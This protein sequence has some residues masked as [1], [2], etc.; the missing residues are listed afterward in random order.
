MAP[1]TTKRVTKVT[2]PARSKAASMSPT[3]HTAPR[4]KRQLKSALSTL[5]SSPAQNQLDA[6][7]HYDLLSTEPES[8]S[9]HRTKGPSK[10]QITDAEFKTKYLAIQDMAW[11][12]A[13]R[14]FKQ[15]PSRP[16]IPSDLSKL[17]TA[18]PELMQ[19]ID[20]TTSCAPTNTWE[21]MIH[22]KKAEIAFSILG[23]A[24]EMHVFGKELFGGSE[25]QRR[26]LQEKDVEMM[27]SD[28]TPPPSSLP[29]PPR[30]QQKTLP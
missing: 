15:D 12:W 11:N 20:M 17:A 21:Q 1:T 4:K 23:K 24:L 22:Y 5:N 26:A 13:Q 18:N 8:P 27:D 30:L 3:D 9:K 14:F 10:Y 28:G 2:K 29:R 16:F 7:L 19:Y 6:Q 25:K